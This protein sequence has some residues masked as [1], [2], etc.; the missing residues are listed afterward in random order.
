MEE[1]CPSFLQRRG[2]DRGP[3]SGEKGNL[4][5]E[6]HAA[7]KGI[8]RRGFDQQRVAIGKDVVSSDTDPSVPVG[9]TEGPNVVVDLDL[10]VGL[11]RNN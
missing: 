11:G 4:V 10:P 6:F 9:Q 5:P 3:R 7:P 2:A 1:T 8:R